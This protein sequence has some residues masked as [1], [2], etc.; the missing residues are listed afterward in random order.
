MPRIADLPDVLL[1]LP[2][3]YALVLIFIGACTIASLCIGVSVAFSAA[4]DFVREFH[5]WKADRD[6]AKQALDAYVEGHA[7]VPQRSR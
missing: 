2:L 1:G 6:D 5:T 7:N 3:P 4:R